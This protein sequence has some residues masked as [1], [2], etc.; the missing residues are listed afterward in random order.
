MFMRGIIFRSTLGALNG[1]KTQSG[2]S[3]ETMMSH[4]D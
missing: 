3:L 2:L 4:H 1:Q